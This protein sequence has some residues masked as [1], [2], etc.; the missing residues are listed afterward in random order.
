MTEPDLSSNTPG[1]DNPLQKKAFDLVAGALP[2]GLEPEKV[3]IR[4][5]VSYARSPIKAHDLAA[6]IMAAFGSVVERLGRMRGLPAQTM[7]LDRRRC[8]LLLNSAQLQYINGYG[9]LIDTWPI[10]PDNGCYRT[11]DGRHVMMIGLHP[12]LRDGLLAHF[13]CANTAEAIQR[14]VEKQNAQ[15]LEDAV[16]AIHL[17]LGIVRSPREWADH[18][19]G[20]A[21]RSQPPISLAVRGESGG[22][23][24]LGRARHR[25]LEGLRVL[26]LTHL[27]A[28]PTIG[29]LLAEQGAEVIKVQPPVGDWVY[30]LWM[31]VSWGKKNVLL[32]LKSTYGKAKFTALLGEADVVINSMRPSA[33]GSLGFDLETLQ[34]LNPN[35]VL[36]N[37]SYAL[38]G[39]PWQDRRGFEQIA[40]AVTG[41]MHV[42]SEG[43]EAP[44]LISVLMNDYLTGYLGAIGTI[45]ALCQREERGGFWKIDAALSRCSTMATDFL[46]PV[47]AEPYEPVLMRDLIEHGIDQMT[48]HGLFTRL[49]PA[50]EFSQTPSMFVL[51]PGLPGSDSDTTNWGFL[52]TPDPV[53]PT[54]VP[55]RLAREGLIRNFLST[56]GIED[57]GDGGGGVSLASK[58]LFALAMALRH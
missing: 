8:G 26:E 57:R 13:D 5:G 37:A 32:D 24:R 25:P 12:H 30:P 50:V 21:T 51:P 20:A 40:Q 31:D 53:E 35:L 3:T 34:A 48:P 28:G 55:S 47:D 33:L 39:T 11:K 54:H 15:D 6:G 52:D 41:V 16:N 9:T 29:R 42:N 44:T 4:H 43:M 7:L 2:F 27:V 1:I 36:A 38:P 19:Q 10:G 49:K 18:P 14:A 45:A 56:H 46:Q 58:S 17:P 22:R 23:R